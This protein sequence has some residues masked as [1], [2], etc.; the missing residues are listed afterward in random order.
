[1]GLKKPFVLP[2]WLLDFF[3]ACLTNGVMFI[4]IG[5]FCLNFEY[6]WG[7]EFNWVFQNN[8]SIEY[9]WVFKK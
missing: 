1:M 2:S 9:N 3:S 7:I 5:N 4:D 6:N 8:G